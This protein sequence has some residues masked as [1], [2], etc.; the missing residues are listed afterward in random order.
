MFPKSAIAKLFPNLKLTGEPVD[1]KSV[2]ESATAKLRDMREA[3]R[4][5]L[6]T[7]ADKLLY[8]SEAEGG[9]FVATG[10][11]YVFVISADKVEMK[12]LAEAKGT[13]AGAEEDGEDATN[14]TF[15][16]AFKGKSVTNDTFKRVFAKIAKIAAPPIPTVETVQGATHISFVDENGEIMARIVQKGADMSYW[17]PA[18]VVEAEEMNE[19]NAMAGA[20]ET[21][22]K[23]ALGCKT[24]EEAK[25][26]LRKA[27][28]VAATIKGK[29]VAVEGEE[30]EI[31]A[32]ATA[33]DEA[34]KAC[35]G[36]GKK[37][38]KPKDDEEEEDDEDDGSEEEE[39]DE[40]MAEAIRNAAACVML[41]HGEVVDASEIETALVETRYMEAIDA[42]ADI[43]EGCGVECGPV[44]EGLRARAH[45]KGR[46]GDIKKA[47][48]RMGKTKDPK[49]T[50]Q[51]GPGANGGKMKVSEGTASN[52]AAGT[53]PSGAETITVSVTSIPEGQADDVAALVRDASGTAT[54]NDAGGIVGHFTTTEHV[55]QFVSALK[56]R[57]PGAKTSKGKGRAEE[58]AQEWIGKV[59]TMP[60][61]DFVAHIAEATA[62]DTP[63]QFATRVTALV[64]AYKATG[65][66]KDM[67][68]KITAVNSLVKKKTGKGISLEGV[69][70]DNVRITLTRERVE[71]FE[72]L[73]K[74]VGIPA[75][76][77]VM[78][79]PTHLSVIVPESYA[80]KLKTVFD[81]DGVAYDAVA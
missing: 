56:D 4:A 61:E 45:K 25:E 76:S 55:D 60:V 17:L 3:G 10:E 78:I 71:E 77:R 46:K 20:I 35:G 68:R 81:G 16:D 79:T 32:G 70:E 80:D 63:E 9:Q 44:I 41:E 18:A 74:K 42:L 24:M 21:H 65:G 50:G 54:A 31:P 58:S 37:D 67:A 64:E 57:I 73:S 52:S 11:K 69:A 5:L 49:P 40:E 51:V 27:L 22:I 59:R 43:A 36:K 33:V 34:G 39:E 26:F 23:R 28:S 62:S 29:K 30:D 2:A 15:K 75:N 66:K 72:S 7:E 8:I 48:G 6:E 14:D 19:A 13:S 1:A 12:P 53:I 38:E 47:A